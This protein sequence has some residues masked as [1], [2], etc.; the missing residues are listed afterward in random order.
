MF[1]VTLVFGIT[2]LTYVNSVG[3]IVS[4]G[5]TISTIVNDPYY[6]GLHMRISQM[7]HCMH[8]SENYVKISEM[9]PPSNGINSRT[10][11]GNWK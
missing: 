10:F 9:R 5:A 3:S 1:R 4:T 11:S 2:S 6:D 7:N 8:S